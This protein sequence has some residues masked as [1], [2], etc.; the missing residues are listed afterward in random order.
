[1]C[2]RHKSRL[3]LGAL[4][5]ALFIILF[6]ETIFAH[7]WEYRITEQDTIDKID[8]EATDAF[9]DY[10]NSEIKL[11]FSASPNVIDF[12]PDG[13]YSYAVLTKNG[14]KYFM[15]DGEKMVEN[16]ILNINSSNPLGFTFT[17][18]F[19]DVAILSQNGVSSFKFAGTDM[20]EVP[21]L[22]IQGLTN[23]VSITTIDDNIYSVL[24]E[25]K[26]KTYG[27]DGS[28]MVEINQLGI[29][30]LSN[31]VAISG[32]KEYNIAV[33]EE[34]K[35]TWYGYTGD[36]MAE[37][38]AL[39]ISTGFTDLKSIAIAKGRVTV[40]D[41]AEVKTFL[42]DGTR[43]SQVTA[44]SVTSG[45][46][47][48]SAVAIRPGS[49]DLLIVDGTNVNYYSFDGEKM[50]KNELL[51][52]VVDDIITG[53]KYV[54]SAIVQS[55]PIM[56]KADMLR[57][58]ANMI[59]PAGTSI[60][61]S[62]TADGANWITRWR[63]RGIETGTVVEVS[64]D[65]GYS[66][67]SIGDVSVASVTSDTKELWAEVIP[68][69]A[70][71]WRAELATT[72][73]D[74][75]PVITGIAGTAVKWEVNNKPKP[76]IVHVPEEGWY[77]TTTPT[78]YWDFVDEDEGDYQ[79]AFQLE[80][81]RQSD[82]G[83]VFDSGKINSS[84]TSFTLPT[85]NLP[86]I[87]GPLWQSGTYAFYVRVKVWDME[88]VESEWSMPGYFKVLAYERPRI[89]EIVSA[90]PEQEIPEKGDDSSHIMILSGMRAADLP[91][92]KAGSK[93]TVVLDSV[94]PILNDAASIAIFPYNDS[95]AIIENAERLY[96]SGYPINR[97]YVSFYTDAEITK[98][99]AGTVV[100]MQTHGAGSEGGT[101]VF[102]MP[103][104]ADGVVVT[105]GSVYE[106]WFVVLEGS[107]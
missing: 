23:A 105:E 38:P 1:M 67:R 17:D 49:Y 64:D 58:R 84:E 11:P 80:V 71:M 4:I 68:G 76:P 54:E 61:W 55:L 18:S 97:W 89:A 69:N 19:P 52:V 10:E 50:V 31:P 93:V 96:D 82:D 57:V 48:P 79:T 104:Y 8:L 62:V 91:K 30:R 77:Y 3:I 99:P 16:T 24:D 70:V 21:H 46:T 44:L 103:P 6:P 86:H 94:G 45:L 65:N 73:K 13:S 15:F 29:E 35:V 88:D 9:I 98:V 102:N 107:E 27:F 37:I 26:V 14:L 74:V 51:S 20:A 87:E 78:F 56:W 47:Q 75:T 33:I 60:T 40:V 53:G 106:D 85:S 95:Q 32:T 72:N 28:T 81:R 42:F 41:D 90:P 43:M 7:E 12:S 39:S 63:A 22:S 100:K 92:V 101:T 25:D 59:L 34:N 83:L 36:G 66:W 2:R 5:I